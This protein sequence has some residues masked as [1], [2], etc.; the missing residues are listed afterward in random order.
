MKHCLIAIRSFINALKHAIRTSLIEWY[1]TNSDLILG[2]CGKKGFGGVYCYWLDQ[3]D[4][5]EFFHAGTKEWDRFHQKVYWQGRADPIKFKELKG[6]VP[7]LPPKPSRNANPDVSALPGKK[8]PY[9]SA[10]KELLDKITAYEGK[11]LPVY[12]VLMEDRYETAM[13][14]GCF[15]YFESAYFDELSAQSHI[16][17]DVEQHELLGFHIR[18]VHLIATENGVVLDINGANISPFDHFG[19]QE[20]CENLAEKII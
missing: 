17:N 15:R 11:R 16:E 3:S 10:T 19:V 6:K 4:T 13:G 7:P 2:F 5:W 8:A 14:D 1:R 12:V 20:I 9:T 18:K